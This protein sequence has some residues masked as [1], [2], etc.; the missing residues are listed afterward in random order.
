MGARAGAGGEAAPGERRVAAAS[1][2]S[3]RPTSR[4]PARQTLAPAWAGAAG[5]AGAAAALEPP[6]LEL[7]PREA[8]ALELRPRE[9]PALV[10]PAWAGSETVARRPDCR[11][12]SSSMPRASASCPRVGTILRS[13]ARKTATPSW[14]RPRPR[15]PER[16]RRWV[17]RRRRSSARGRPATAPRSSARAFRCRGPTSRPAAAHACGTSRSGDPFVLPLAPRSDPRYG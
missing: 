4:T 17:G 10:R 14:P 1:T 12:G 7:A 16:T 11:P 13:R 6:A 5:A 9:A 3:L 15:R 8:P 2:R